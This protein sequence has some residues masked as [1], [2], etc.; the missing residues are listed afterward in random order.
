MSD[1]ETI[2]EDCKNWVNADI[3]E[4]ETIKIKRQIV[5]KATRCIACGA[6]ECSVY[7]RD[8]YEAEIIGE[9]IGLCESCKKAIEWAKER[10][11]GR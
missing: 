9:T 3:P 7:D 2:I 6:W 4:I 11:E 1:K 10:M 5:V 8:K